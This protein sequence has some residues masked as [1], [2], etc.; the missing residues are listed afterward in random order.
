[1]E[2]EITDAERIP[3]S[4]LADG[5]HRQEFKVAQRVRRKKSELRSKN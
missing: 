4:E 1:M 3:S 2:K 5:S